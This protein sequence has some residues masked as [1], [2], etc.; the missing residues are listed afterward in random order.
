VTYYRRAVLIAVSAVA[1]LSAAAVYASTTSGADDAKAVPLPDAKVTGYCTALHAKLPQ[2]VDG[3][4]L[5]DLKPRSALTA[6]WGDPA[7]VLRCG[8]PRPAADYD[9]STWGTEVGG[10]S[11][12]YQQGPHGSTVMTT[13]LRKA[14]VELALPRKYAHDATPLSELAAAVSQ[15]IPAGL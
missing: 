10:V 11:W 15:T 5:H 9:P 7:I 8:V 12:S 2:K 1:C 14:Y 4:P 3:L 6:G 13:T